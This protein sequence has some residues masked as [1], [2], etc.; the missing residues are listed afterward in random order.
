MAKTKC[1]KHI[2]MGVSHLV[3]YLHSYQSS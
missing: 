2:I 3:F 1:Y